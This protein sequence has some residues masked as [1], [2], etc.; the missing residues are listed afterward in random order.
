MEKTLN[1][2]QLEDTILKKLKERKIATFEQ[3]SAELKISREDIK[4]ILDL[5]VI[6]GKVSEREGKAGC[7]NVCS[8]CPLRKVCAYSRISGSFK[9][10]IVAEKER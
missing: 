3:L 1:I 8:S 5:L 9:Y 2:S 6:E 7:D 4:K 10:Y